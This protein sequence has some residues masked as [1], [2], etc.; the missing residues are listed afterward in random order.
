MLAG[1]QWA[2]DQRRRRRQHEPRRRRRRRHRPAQPGGRRAVGDVRHAVRRSRPGTTAAGPSTV[3]SPGAADAAL[4]VGAVDGNDAMAGFS[5]RGPRLGD[6]AVKPEVVAPGVDITAARAAG[7]ALGDPVDD[8]IHDAQ[9]HLD[10][11]AARGRPRRDPQAG[12]S[13]LGRRAAQG[14]DHRQHRPVADASALRRRHRPRR[15]A[16][17]PSTRPCSRTP[18]VNLGFFPWPQRDLAPTRTP[19]TYTNLGGAAVDA[20]AVAGR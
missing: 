14:R 2:V 16:A 18:R 9:R 10:G 4:T 1:M 11:H 7:T 5:S 12:A 13:R 3:T 20:R 19:L 8:P 17:R 6:G 15:R